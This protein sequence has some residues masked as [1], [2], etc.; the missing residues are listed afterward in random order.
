MLWALNFTSFG[1]EEH[2]LNPYHAF[3]L[4]VLLHKNIIFFGTSN[5]YMIGS[6]LLF[7]NYLD[8]HKDLKN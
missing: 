1:G 6:C 2:I 7:L 8:L 4:N 3:V 5:G